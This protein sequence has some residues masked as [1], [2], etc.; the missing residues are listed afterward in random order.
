M[1]VTFSILAHLCPLTLI[2]EAAQIGEKPAWQEVALAA[3][4]LNL[5]FGD[6]E[7]FQQGNLFFHQLAESLRIA[8][9][10]AVHELILHLCTWK[11]IYDCTAHTEFIQVSIREMFN[12]LLHII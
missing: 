4:E 2:A 5:L 11:V 1:Q 10:V 9:T 6:D 12:N 8:Q 7:V 3:H